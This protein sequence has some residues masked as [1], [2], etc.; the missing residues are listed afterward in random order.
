GLHRR[1][2]GL[3]PERDVHMLEAVVVD[4]DRQLRA[5]D[6]ERLE[7]LLLAL[8]RRHRRDRLL[9]PAEHDA[10]PLAL[11]LHRNDAAARLEPD[12]LE[13]ERPGEDEGR[14]EDRVPRE[15]DL[16]S[17]RED[18]DPRVRAAGAGVDED[19]LGEVDLARELLQALLRDRA[20][21]GEDGELIAGER[22]VR[23]D[24]DD[25]EAEGRRHGPTLA[26]RSRGAAPT[27]DEELGIGGYT[28]AR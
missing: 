22:G 5:R 26:M 19:G 27:T 3:R 28:P 15:L 2:L 20:R 7:Q 12:H 1:D 9:H 25:V 18:P 16:D 4:L 21:V 10:R 14:T 6:P 17:R 24:V 8:E 11:Q 13:L 23:E